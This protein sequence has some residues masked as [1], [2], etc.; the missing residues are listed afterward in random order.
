MDVVC[1]LY[2]GGTHQSPAESGVYGDGRHSA[3]T[4]KTC[5]VLSWGEGT[6]ENWVASRGKR[7]GL[8]VM[9]WGLLINYPFWRNRLIR[10]E[11]MDGVDR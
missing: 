3:G 6:E 2:F 8:G 4:Q 7:T 5:Q 9:G 11:C 10:M 1:G